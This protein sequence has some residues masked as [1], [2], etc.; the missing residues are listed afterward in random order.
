V[1]DL[2]RVS[3]ALGFVVASDDANESMFDKDVLMSPFRG[4]AVPDGY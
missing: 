1:D 4:V 3:G 2:G